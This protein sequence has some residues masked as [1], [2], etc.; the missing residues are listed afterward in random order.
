[1]SSCAASCCTCCPKASSAFATLAS[2]P[3]ADAPLF[4]RFAFKDSTQYSHR[5]PNQKL[6]PRNRSRF[7]SV[8]NV[9]APWWSSRDLPLPRSNCVLH[10]VS[11]EPP[12]ETTISNLTHSVRLTTGSRGVPILPPNHLPVFNFGSKSRSTPT[13][14]TTQPIPPALFLPPGPVPRSPSPNHQYH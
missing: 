6:L 14:T 9:V 12:H 2:S 4:C 7:G 8:P 11:P 13:Q 10:P 3:T 1:M 5:A